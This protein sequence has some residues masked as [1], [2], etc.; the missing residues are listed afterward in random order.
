VVGFLF[1]LAGLSYWEWCLGLRNDWHEW[2]THPVPGWVQ[3]LLGLPFTPFFGV[4]SCPRCGR[5]LCGRRRLF[6][7]GWCGWRD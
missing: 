7:C 2:Q 1:C 5:R 4:A 3:A 6:A